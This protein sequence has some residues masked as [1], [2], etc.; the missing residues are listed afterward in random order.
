MTKF[1]TNIL[2]A[3]VVYSLIVDDFIH[4][5]FASIEGAEAYANEYLQ[6]SDYVIK[7]NHLA[8]FNSDYKTIVNRLFNA[9]RRYCRLVDTHQAELDL[10]EYGSNKYFNTEERQARS[11]NKAY[12][13]VLELWDKLPKAEKYAFNKQY[14]KLFGY[15]AMAS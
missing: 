11:E 9:D 4:G 15:E 2:G 5:N 13:K 8:P 6:Y 14:K 3:T 10:I 12:N 7:K 1:E